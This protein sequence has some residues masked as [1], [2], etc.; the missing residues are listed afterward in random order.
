M[1]LFAVC[2]C[3]FSS[4]RILR[5]PVRIRRSQDLLVHNIGCSKVVPLAVLQHIL[6]R[7]LSW[8]PE[9][10][11]LHA[12]GDNTYGVLC[13]IIVLRVFLFLTWE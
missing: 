13:P 11:F 5:N 7:A 3:L 2:C 1:P 9:H 10:N 6:R 8:V 4:C 12:A